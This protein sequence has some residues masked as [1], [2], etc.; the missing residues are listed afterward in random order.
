MSWITETVDEYKAGKLTL[1]QLADKLGQATYPDPP[2]PAD[3]GY[4]GWV[5][6]DVG[7]GKLHDGTWEEVDHLW[8]IRKLNTDEYNTIVKAAWAHHS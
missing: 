6:G 2:P 8:A 3:G 5:Q 7:D 4:E 1:T